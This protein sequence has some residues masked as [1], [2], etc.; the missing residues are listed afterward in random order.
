MPE[1][2]KSKSQFVKGSGTQPNKEIPPEFLPPSDPSY[3]KEL[4][5]DTEFRDKTTARDAAPGAKWG[6]AEPDNSAKII[7]VDDSV[8]KKDF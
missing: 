4:R 3:K 6:K 8:K 2:Q 1:E 7:S 5:G